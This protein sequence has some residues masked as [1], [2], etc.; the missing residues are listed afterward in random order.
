VLAA[1]EDVAR[2][3]GLAA[4]GARVIAESNN[5]VVRLPA[6]E[7]VAKASTTVLEG[8]GPAALGRELALGRRLADRGAPIAAPAPDPI[9]GPHEASGVVLTLWRYVAPGPKPENGDRMLG[10]AVRLVQAAL[11]DLAPELPPL[12][13]TIDRANRLLQDS[14]ATPSLTAADR[15]LGRRAHARLMQLVTALGDATGLHAEPHDGNIVWGA[16]GPVLIDFEAA[17]RGPVEWDLA[18]LPPAALDAFPGR[19]Q[20]ATARLRAGVSFCVA[21]WCLANPDPTLD[22]TEAAVIHWDALRR[23]WLEIADLAPRA[24]HDHGRRARLAGDLLPVVGM[25]A[26]PVPAE[27]QELGVEALAAAV[28]HVG[29]GTT[30][31]YGGTPQDARHAGASGHRE[32]NGEVGAAD[33]LG[34]VDVRVVAV[35]HPFGPPDELT[36]HPPELLPGRLPPPRPVGEAV[37]VDQ[38]QP[39][40]LR[41]VPGQEALP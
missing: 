7:L 34:L 15:A 9:A 4:A 22:V 21:A 10:D 24:Q 30:D 11:A 17:C 25:A 13:G 20:E 29:T 14:A 41:Q 19:D 36:V 12:R 23:S 8:R 26:V 31:S 35:D 1:V 40:D 32:H 16:Y 33:P 38:R 6:E 28:R 37:E 27:A 5:T 39:R 2:R 3:L 18:Y